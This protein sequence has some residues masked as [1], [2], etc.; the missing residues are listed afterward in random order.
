MSGVHYLFHTHGVNVELE[1]ESPVNQRSKIQ[2]RKSIDESL[3]KAGSYSISCGME[4]NIHLCSKAP[5]DIIGDLTLSH[6]RH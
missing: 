6:I 2:L 1:M 4:G 5:E 3:L